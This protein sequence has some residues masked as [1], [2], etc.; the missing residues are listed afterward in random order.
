MRGRWREWRRGAG[1]LLIE[2]GGTRFW[3]KGSRV[4]KPVDDVGDITIILVIL[5]VIER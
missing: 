3:G 5:L 1:S 4:I 2:D